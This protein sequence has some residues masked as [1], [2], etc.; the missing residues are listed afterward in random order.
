[1]N[2]ARIAGMRAR[3]WLTLAAVGVLQACGG[4]RQKPP[5]EP[6][7]PPAFGDEGG[8]GTESVPASNARVQAGIEAIQAGDFAGAKA[9]L[10]EAVVQDP[11]DPQAPYYLGVALEGLDEMD[12]AR[13]AYEKALALDPKLLEARINLS[14]IL[15]DEGEGQRA[16]PIVEEGLKL[17]PDHPALLLNHAL[18]LDLAGDRK[19][20]VAA[21]AKAVEKTP[22]DAT[23]RY[24][25]AEN[26]AQDGQSDAVK[27]ELS[28]VLGATKDLQLTVAAAQLSSKVGDHAT[29]ISVL[30]GVIAK[31][32]TPDFYV[33]RGRC[34]AAKGD[35][36]GAEADYRAALGQDAN[37][38]GAQYYLGV[39][40]DGQGKG[41]E[42]KKAFNKAIETGKGT[43]FEGL[44][45]KALEGSK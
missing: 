15:I 29:C 7:N 22:D 45:R 16:V 3:A 41:A 10:T 27:R 20:A 19:G 35:G 42:A 23:L 17:A 31:Q 28:Q 13:A 25:Y 11:Q 6:E 1:M 18:A 38:A 4:A 37:F 44:A 32:A 21:Y 34:K 30:D 36:K 39:L 26:L 2:G 12:A 5:T 8:G 14:G 43:P 24:A 9:N 40:L 33:R